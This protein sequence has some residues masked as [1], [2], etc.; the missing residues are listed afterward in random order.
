MSKEKE[1]ASFPPPLPAKG[2]PETRCGWPRGGPGG[3]TRRCG[4][5]CGGEEPQRAQLVANGVWHEEGIA[6]GGGG[7]DGAA[8]EGVWLLPPG[9]CPL[10]ELV[11]AH[12]SVPPGRVAK[13]AL[14]GGGGGEELRPAVG[15]IH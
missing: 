10:P 8:G 5:W 9:E 6:G 15:R 2:G 12:Q 4:L 7:A 11:C 3:G 14:E 1:L 13:L